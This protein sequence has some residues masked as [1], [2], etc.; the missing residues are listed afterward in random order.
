MTSYTSIAYTEKYK[1]VKVTFKGPN[2]FC[3][4]KK[5]TYKMYSIVVVLFKYFNYDS[6]KVFVT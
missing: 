3:Y 4:F 2:E 5:L 6:I 1:S